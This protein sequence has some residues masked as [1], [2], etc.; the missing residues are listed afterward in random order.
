M[1]RTDPSPMTKVEERQAKVFEILKEFAAAAERQGPHSNIEHLTDCGDYK[2][3]CEDCVHDLALRLEEMWL[4]DDRYHT[5][6]VNPSQ[7]W[8]RFAKRMMEEFQI[9]NR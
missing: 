4:D 2:R 9:I 7:T 1:D 5:I 8:L 3:G 6:V